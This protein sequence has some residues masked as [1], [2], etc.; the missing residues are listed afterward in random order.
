[1][2]S[3]ITNPSDLINLSL[4]RIGFEHAIGSLYE[5]SKAAKQALRLY[6]E[7]RDEMLRAVDY[8]F[9]ERNVQMTLLK[10]APAGGYF[11][12][13]LW[14]PAVNP[15]LPWIFES[16]YPQDCLKVRSVKPVP[17]FVLNF[18][19]QPNVFA[20]ENDNSFNPPQKVILHNV[21]NA[22]LV[23]TGQITDPATWESDFVDALA[24]KLALRLAPVMANMD[25]AK[26]E[27]SDAAQSTAVAEEREG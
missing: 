11:P 23:Y 20:V 1:M 19:P 21:P 7:T 15:P 9:A 26:M 16:A 5:G 27:A 17:L 8:G 14:N 10:Q 12:P 6:S 22:L 25:A 13:N 18:D 4:G 2:A 3:V 24:S